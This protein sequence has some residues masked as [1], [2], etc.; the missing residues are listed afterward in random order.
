MTEVMG[1]QNSKGSQ[2]NQLKDARCRVI[3][4][5]LKPPETHRLHRSQL[6]NVVLYSF[7]LGSNWLIFVS[8]FK[9]LIFIGRYSVEWTWRRCCGYCVS[10]KDSNGCYMWQVVVQQWLEAISSKKRCNMCARWVAEWISAHSW[11]MCLRACVWVFYCEWIC[12]KVCVWERLCLGELSGRAQRAEKTCAHDTSQP[13]YTIE[14]RERACTPAA[15][16]MIPL[17]LPRSLTPSSSSGS[18]Q[19]SDDLMMRE[20]TL[21]IHTQQTSPLAVLPSP[22]DTLAFERVQTCTY[23]DTHTP[24]AHSEIRKQKQI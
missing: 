16:A 12:M 8:D 20:T 22:T 2:N 3:G 4:L 6:L 10:G 1:I 17:S 21:I 7:S 15:P 14:E 18:H 5:S 24:T 23:N 19:D 9:E 11:I 13:H